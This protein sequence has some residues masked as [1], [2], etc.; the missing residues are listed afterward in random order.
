VPTKSAPPAVARAKAEA[1]TDEELM[2]A[3]VGGDE[4][5]FREIFARYAPRLF[6]VVRRQVASADDANDIVQQTFLQLHRARADFHQGARLRPWLFTIALNLKREF[7]RKRGRRPES[8][9][10]LD[11]RSDP[12]SAPVEPDRDE[13]G[14]L[15]REA[16]ARLPQNQREVI[17][18][19]W[20]EELPMAEVA[21]IVGAS[22]SA[23]K[24]RAHR[25]YE[26]LRGLV[27]ELD[28]NRG[29]GRDIPGKDGP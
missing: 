13:R 1:P 4:A 12:A 2:R 8:P 9:L 27:E 5:A 22:V 29:G 3:Y 17:E 10:D 18:L 23:V 16:L 24:V 11:G 6:R 19:H 25:G 7:F 28:R 15:L 26:R 20:F 14:R 21:V